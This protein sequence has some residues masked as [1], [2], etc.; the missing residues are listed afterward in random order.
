[1][2]SIGIYS[3]AQCQKYVPSKKSLKIPKGVIRTHKSKKNRQHNGKKKRDKGH[4]TI[5]KTYT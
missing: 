5:Y 4:T 2:D 3:M 1:M